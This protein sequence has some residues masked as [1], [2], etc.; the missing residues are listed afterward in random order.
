MSQKENPLNLPSGSS[1]LNTLS[2]IPKTCNIPPLT[3]SYWLLDQAQNSCN[4]GSPHINIHILLPFSLLLIF[5][6][7]LLK[8]KQSTHYSL[9]LWLCVC[10]SP[11]EMALL[12]YSTFVNLTFLPTSSSAAKL[13]S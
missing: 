11:I 4:G 1:S 12:L 10:P 3:P 5:Y 6:N 9:K 8:L 2:C 13:F 7:L